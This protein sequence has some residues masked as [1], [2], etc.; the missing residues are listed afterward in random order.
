MEHATSI[1]EKENGYSLGC[2]CGWTEVATK[3]E[4]TKMHPH[5]EEDVFAKA[6]CERHLVMDGIWPYT[7]HGK[8]EQFVDGEVMIMHEWPFNK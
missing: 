3:A 5:R 8:P 1:T 7:P 2:E 6:L 4:K